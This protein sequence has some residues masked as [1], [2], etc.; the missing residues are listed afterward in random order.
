MTRA[1]HGICFFVMPCSTKRLKPTGGVICAI[2]TTITMKMPN[3]M[4]SMPAFWM[5]GRITPMVS[6]TME[7]PSRKQPRTMKKTMSAK[8]SQKGVSPSPVMNSARWR[9]NPM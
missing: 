3:Q 1:I 9:G 6:T 4:R 7:M 2:S 5:V 8:S